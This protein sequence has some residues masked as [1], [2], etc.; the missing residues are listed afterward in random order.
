MKLYRSKD[1]NRFHAEGCRYA[2]PKMEWIWARDK[3]EREVW[4]AWTNGVY[5]CEICKPLPHG[6]GVRT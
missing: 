2:L 5:P 6:K 1:G 4:G 3:S